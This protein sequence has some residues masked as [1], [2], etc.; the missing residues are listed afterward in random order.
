MWS[1]DYSAR[2]L[3]CCLVL[4]LAACGFSLRSARE[5]PA[6]MSQT[7][8]QAGTPGGVLV[9]YLKRFLR[10]SSV[11]VIEYPAPDAAVLKVR[12]S[13]TRRALSVGTD[14]KVLEYEIQ[15]SAT[16]SLTVPG[17]ERELPERTISLSRDYMFDRLAVLA[18]G[19]EEAMLVRDMQRELAR[20]IVERIAAYSW[21]DAPATPK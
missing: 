6:G 16:F 4:S 12:E 17:M 8:I 3:L 5:L 19:E 14:A 21:Q 11:H 18:T 7:Y 20:M 1:L 13:S 9:N 2:W 15:Y 10:D